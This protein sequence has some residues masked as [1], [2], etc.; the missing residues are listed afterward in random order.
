LTSPAPLTLDD[1]V[2][3]GLCI[4]CGLC[5]SLAGPERVRIVMTPEGRERP[6]VEAP[7]DDAALTLINAVCPGL[8]VEGPDPAA[9]ADG[10]QWDAVWGPATRIAKGHAAD[11]SIRFQGSAG[12]G[13]SALAIY[14]LESGRVDFIL[15]V[16][17]SSE[18]PM[19]TKRHLSFDRAQVMAAAGSRYGPAAPLVDFAQLL[20]RGRPFAF[21][22]K[23]C[24]VAALRNLARHDPRVERLVPY[25]LAFV[26]GGASEFAKTRD[27]VQ[28]F[29]LEEKDVT[30]LRYRGM[31]NPGLTRVVARDGRNFT[32]TYGELWR[33]ENNWML[34]F[35]CKIC[36]DA[37]GELADVAVS[38]V[39]PNGEP[40]G[41][42]A[43]FNGFIARTAK[44][45]TLLED[46]ERDGALVLI[47][48]RDFRFLDNVQPHQVHK[49]QA[50][51]ARLAAMR[52]AG[53]ITP[54]YT[55]LRLEAAAATTDAAAQQASYAGMCDRLKRGD[56]REPAAPP[57]ADRARE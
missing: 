3:A 32:T 54:S 25:V 36:A 4:G 9:S 28:G 22:G 51:T 57:M 27:L 23:P 5:E 55:G 16:A 39:W 53:A 44:G 43:G 45:R 38:D 15:H 42:N 33:D 17:A 18:Q 40:Q 52:D 1:I 29:G 13:L 46:A 56:N 30:L 50:L 10:T 20:D 47:E 48:D 34:Q 26:C 24:D 6:A 37:I 49:K 8:K 19:R 2:R 41:E 7:L 31:G 35:R 21:I 12:G 11:P 14:L